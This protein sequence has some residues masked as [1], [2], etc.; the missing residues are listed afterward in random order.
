MYRTGIGVDVHPLVQGRELVLGGVA[1]PHDTGLDGHSDGDALVHAVIDACLGATNLGD[2]GAHFPSSDPKYLGVRSTILLSETMR[3]LQ[4]GRWRLEYL[5]ATIVAERPKLRPYIG[6][7]RAALAEAMQIEY[8]LISLKATT[9]D[10][11][12]FVGREEGICCI[13]VVTISKA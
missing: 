6:D 13:V 9:T 11:L 2:I 12:G 5:D 1:I 4:A 3:L 7:M 8:E 10:H